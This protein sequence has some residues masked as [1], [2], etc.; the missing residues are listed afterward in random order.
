MD[1]SRECIRR[2]AV[3]HIP[4]SYAI[5]SSWDVLIFLC[6][7]STDPDSF[8]YHEKNMAVFIGPPTGRKKSAQLK[9]NEKLFRHI[10]GSAVPIIRGVHGILLRTTLNGRLGQI[11]TFESQQEKAFNTMVKVA[12]YVIVGNRYYFFFLEHPFSFEIPKGI[13]PNGLRKLQEN[14]VEACNI[15]WDTLK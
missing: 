12:S 1:E 15:K 11:L 5:H 9:I 10:L 6:R 7:H 14:A 3:G 13:S 4:V 8:V 2:G